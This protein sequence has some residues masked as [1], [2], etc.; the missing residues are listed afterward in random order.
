MAD[1]KFERRSEISANDYR[2]NA[3]ATFWPQNYGGFLRL[4][5]NQGGSRM[6]QRTRILA[7]ILGYRGWRIVEVV[8]E[9]P[10]GVPMVIWPGGN[11]QPSTTMIFR[12]ERRWT[13]RCPECG[14]LCHKHH[15][16]LNPRR[17]KDMSCSQH[18]VF[19]EASPVRVT[20]ER[21]KSTSVE[22]LPWADP[23]QR[24]TRRFQQNLALQSASM[25]IMHVAV[26]H[27]LSWGTVRRAEGA[28]LA[29]WDATREH[30]PL[31]QVGIDEKYL[32]RRN[33]LEHDYVTIVSNLETGE[34]LWIGP[35]REEKT[36]AT[37]LA[38]LKKKQ[39]IRIQLFAM[40][41]HRPFWNAIKADENL[42]HAVIVHDPFHIV[43]RANKAV[44]EIRKDTFF[45]AGQE[46][47][48][49]GR[50]S[51]WLVLRSWEKNTPED[52]A[53]LTRL[54]TYN[55]QLARAYQIK[56]ELRAVLRA[57][58]RPAMEIGFRR[59]LRRTCLKE[60]KHL[61]SLHDSLVEHQEEILALGDHHPST[62][63]TEALNNNWETLVRRARGYRDYNYLLLK[64]RFM[65]ANPVRTASGTQRFLVL[66]LPEPLRHAA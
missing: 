24:Q 2:K 38:T 36:V 66:G 31:R 39:K 46:M 50:G 20:C 59:I 34:P 15:E 33:K 43:K 18:P 42:A 27:G 28:A 7:E 13:A 14:E 53:E 47:R 37:W 8:F 22:L 48:T 49:V 9:W 44:N 4:S 1:K 55:H 29:R 23:Y 10:D 45:R 61:R 57:P 64:L 26:M 51:H 30:P 17:W 12:V 54:F 35:G 32:G 19:I 60:H 56:E 52:Q 25:P 21:C 11:P 58:D 65:T 63:R 5:K 6:S 16:T 41:M 62:G 3:L 40:D